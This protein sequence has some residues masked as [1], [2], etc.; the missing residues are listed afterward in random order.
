MNRFWYHCHVKNALKLHNLRKGSRTRKNLDSAYNIF[1][2]FIWIL[3][4]I[5]NKQRCLKL[6]EIAEKLV[7]FSVSCK[8][9]PDTVTDTLATMV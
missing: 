3:E 7:N 8:C 2:S 6:K 1:R 5:F 9:E 4:F